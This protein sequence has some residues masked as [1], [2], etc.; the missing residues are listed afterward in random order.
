M[1]IVGIAIG[2]I[3][4][5]SSMNLTN[6]FIEHIIMPLLYPF[7]KKIIKDPDLKVEVNG[8]YL[9]IGELISNLITFFVSLILIC[10]LMKIGMKVTPK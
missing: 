1:N 5:H 3:V 4:A 6:T 10:F 8:E 2:L 9:Y 7:L